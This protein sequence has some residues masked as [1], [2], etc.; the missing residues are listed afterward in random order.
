MGEIRNREVNDAYTTAPCAKLESRG[1]HTD[2][3]DIEIILIAPP[4]YQQ[5]RK[6]S[7]GGGAYGK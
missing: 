6:S 4:P 7:G 3:K 1:G 5:Q 2:R